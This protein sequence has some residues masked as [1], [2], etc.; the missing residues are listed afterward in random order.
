MKLLSSPIKIFL[1]D[2]QFLGGCRTCIRIS[3]MLFILSVEL[4]GDAKDFGLVFGW[5]V[6]LFQHGLVVADLPFEVGDSFQEAILE[7]H[8]WLP[9]Q[10]GLSYCEVWTALFWIIG[11]REFL[12]D[13]LTG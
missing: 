1:W 2:S 3:P 6:R 10:E 9:V 5:D 8:N 7:G 12:V 13:D 4:I 11:C